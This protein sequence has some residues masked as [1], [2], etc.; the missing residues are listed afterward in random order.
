MEL[1]PIDIFVEFFI[2][3][4]TDLEQY[5][6]DC[7]SLIVGEAGQRGIEFDGY[8]KQKWI[9]SSDT[10]ID[11]DEDYFEDFNRKKLYV[12]LSSLYNKEIYDYLCD[13]YG[14]ALQEKPSKEELKKRIQNLIHKGV[15]FD[16]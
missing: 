5:F 16:L 7:Y 14:V 4:P 6:E 8:L 13:A 12:Y 3:E 1:R 9:Q 10:I 11:F 2:N 15:N